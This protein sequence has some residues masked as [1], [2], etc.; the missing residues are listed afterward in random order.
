MHHR[1]E[2]TH[3]I[4]D[5]RRER[6]LT[7]AELAEAAGRPEFW[8]VAAL[9]GQAPLEREEADRVCEKLGLGDEEARVLTE[10]PHRGSLDTAI[11]TDPTIYRLYEVVQ[12]YGPTI[13][14]LIHEKFG[15]G[16]MSAI[17]FSMEVEREDRD[18]GAFVQLNMRGKFLPYSQPARTEAG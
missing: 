18:E 12:V 13:K 7:Y 2:V 17:T 9:L 5:A 15:D 3:R 1:H 14:A 10:I 6:G 4:D 8:T 11:P 16:I